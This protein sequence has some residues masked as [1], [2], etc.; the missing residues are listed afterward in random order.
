MNDGLI[1]PKRYA[2]ALL[3]FAAARGARRRSEGGE[4]A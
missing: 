1:T 2:K 4:A 3:T